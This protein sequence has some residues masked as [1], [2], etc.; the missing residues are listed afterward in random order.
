MAR[1]DGALDGRWWREHVRQG[2]T[3]E[4]VG[5]VVDGFMGRLGGA[6]GMEVFPIPVRRMPSQKPVYYLAFGTRSKL[7]LWHFADS[8]AR[9]TQTW[10]EELSMRE[11][12]KKAAYGQDSLFGDEPI[13]MGP[14]L[15]TVENQALPVIAENIARLVARR[16]P[17]RVGAYPAEI[18]GDYLGRVREKTVRA[19]IKKLNADGRTASD[20]K[21]RSV[22]DLVVNPTR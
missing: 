14:K 13:M 17:C 6:T 22:A 19:A 18:F 4:A 9:A 16:G 20:G 1:L 11:D 7:G 10:W 3:E 15:E 21:G 8:T 2:M 5:A 12:A